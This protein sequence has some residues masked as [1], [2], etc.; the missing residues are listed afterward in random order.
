VALQA[1][2]LPRMQ[3]AVR[4]HIGRAKESLMRAWREQS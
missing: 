2:D 1:R 3:A 4:Q